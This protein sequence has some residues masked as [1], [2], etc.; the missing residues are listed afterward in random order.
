MAKRLN[1]NKLFVVSAISR[2][3]IAKELNSHIE[4]RLSDLPANVRKL[5]KGDFKFFTLTDPRLTDK[6]CQEYAD[7][8]NDATDIGSEHA[9]D[10]IDECVSTMHEAVLEELGITFPDDEEVANIKREAMLESL[11]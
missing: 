3:S 8:L 1:P 5:V 2:K 7:A 9:E 10:W 6:V 4:Y 11:S